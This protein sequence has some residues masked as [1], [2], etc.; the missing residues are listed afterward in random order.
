MPGKFNK[1]SLSQKNA[2]KNALV[3]KNILKILINYTVFIF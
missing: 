1:K 2:N 3:L